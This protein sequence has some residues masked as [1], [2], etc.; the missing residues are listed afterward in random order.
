M[1]RR[2]IVG[3][4]LIRTFFEIMPKSHYQT[5][6][7]F[8]LLSPPYI[9]NWPT[10]PSRYKGLLHLPFWARW[11]S[12]LVLHRHEA[13]INLRTV[14]MECGVCFYDM[15]LSLGT[16]SGI[17][18][19]WYMNDVHWYP[20]DIPGAIVPMIVRYRAAAQ[21]RLGIASL[22]I[23]DRLSPLKMISTVLVASCCRY[24]IS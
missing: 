10:S 13:E 16:N 5:D 6:R 11:I 1:K 21:A 24:V 20:R 9:R 19:R 17:L 8:R 22:M 23:L 3:K 4:S 15:I 7:C 18:K 14:K 2:R 12:I